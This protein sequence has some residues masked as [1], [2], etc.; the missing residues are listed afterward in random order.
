M[1]LVPYSHVFTAVD[2]CALPFF[3][4]YTIPLAARGA[5]TR[6]H[7]GRAPLGLAYAR[8]TPARPCRTVACR[9]GGDARPQRRRG[10]TAR[11]RRPSRLPLTSAPLNPQQAHSAIS[12]QRTRAWSDC[13]RF[14]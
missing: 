12:A 9:R 13:R 2:V 8:P 4:L 6:L 1:I 14:L 3:T 7:L 11:R 10:A 5:P